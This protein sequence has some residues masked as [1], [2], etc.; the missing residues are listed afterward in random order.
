[1]L[2]IVE[3]NRPWQASTLKPDIMGVSHDFR[4]PLG[5]VSHVPYLNGDALTRWWSW[6]D[7]VINDLCDNICVSLLLVYSHGGNHCFWMIYAKR[8]FAKVFEDTRN[9][10][11]EMSSKRWSSSYSEVTS[12]S[13]NCLCS[14][15]CSL[16]FPM[17]NPS[18]VCLNF[19]FVR[20]ELHL[21]PP[22]WHGS[23]RMFYPWKLR[24]W[25]EDL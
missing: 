19:P 15:F 13:V 6:V 4:E 10:V 8:D 7:L 5:V 3:W 9:V 22:L 14:S 12:S 23:M 1:M 11:S 25:W 17:K 20:P 21:W 24:T 2:F 18:N 16:S